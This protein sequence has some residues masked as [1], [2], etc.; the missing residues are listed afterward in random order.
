M[1]N[2]KAHGI[3]LAKMCEG[4]AGAGIDLEL[5]LPR[6]GDSSVSLESFYELKNPFKIKMLR[7]INLWPATRIGFNLSAFTFALAY[8]FYL[9]AERIRGRRGLI[10]T[11]DLDQFSFFLIPL[12]GLPYF[13]ETHAAKRKNF[14]YRFFLRNA[15]GIIT[16]NSWIK[17]DL[18]SKFGLNPGK[19][20]VFPNGIDLRMFDSELAQKEARAKLNLAEQAKI[21]AYIGRFYNWKG[22]GILPRAAEILPESFTFYLVGG[23]ERQFKDIVGIESLPRN[24]I[25]LGERDYREIPLWI[26]AADL[27]LVL[28]TKANAYSYYQ[29]SP[30]K[31]FEYMAAGKPIVASQTPALEEIVSE[32]E[33]IF[34]EPDSA[35]SLAI[36]VRSALEN[37]E[38][39]TV[40]SARAYDKVRQFSWH[41]RAEA[42]KNF[43]SQRI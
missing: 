13:F 20:M 5:I 8:F 9:L 3:Q 34:Y 1:P 19:I 17:N 41:N 12:L 38:R 16:I 42:V 27:L 21:I 23:T 30:L 33:A 4:F 32:R 7:V 6:K 29:T 10:Y 11:I 15:Q 37:P 28:G 22:L 24:I 18:I 14:L 43:I 25:C 40:I 31:I 26:R 2:P 36:A 39:L 35:E